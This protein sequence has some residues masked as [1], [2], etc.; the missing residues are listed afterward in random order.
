[1]ERKYGREEEMEWKKWWLTLRHLESQRH[2]A[3]SKKFCIPPFIMGI[4][5]F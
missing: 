3:S 5:S 1:M 4:P 2:K